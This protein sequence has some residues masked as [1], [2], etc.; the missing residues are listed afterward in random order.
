MG[1]AC[2]NG[3]RQIVTAPL[4]LGLELELFYN[5]QMHST[6]RGYA[7]ARTFSRP[8]QSCF[9]QSFDLCHLRVAEKGETHSNSGYLQTLTEPKKAGTNSN[10]TRISQA[11]VT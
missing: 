6:I 4:W 8:H 2:M 5:K 1:L 10:P 3:V 7:V 11:K 9:G